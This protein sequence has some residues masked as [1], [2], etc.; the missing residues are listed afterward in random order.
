LFII[1]RAAVAIWR[2]RI[3]YPASPLR[4]LLRL[5]LILPLIAVLDLGAIAGS[6]QWFLTDKL[7]LGAETVGVKNER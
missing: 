1:A 3:C 7:H 2:N 5:T 6:V 4:N